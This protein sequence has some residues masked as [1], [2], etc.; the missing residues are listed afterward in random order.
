MHSDLCGAK[1]AAQGIGFLLGLCSVPIT[2]GPPIAGL[3]YDETQSYC[4]SFIMA[5]IPALIGAALMTLIR[6]LRD[7]RVDVCDK[8]QPEDQF[9]KLLNKPAWTEGNNRQTHGFHFEKE[10]M[11]K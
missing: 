11:E 8:Q 4:T 5:G 1:G 6:F 7:E 10:K 3:L 9:H 2:V